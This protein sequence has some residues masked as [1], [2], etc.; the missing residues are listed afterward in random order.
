MFEIIYFDPPYGTGSAGRTELYTV[1]LALLAENVLLR[2]GGTLLVE[3]AKQF[4]VPDTVGSLTRSRQA[5]YG[6]TVVSFYQK[7][8]VDL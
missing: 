6:D 8:A 1:C 3:H 5:N 2:T 4:V 7:E